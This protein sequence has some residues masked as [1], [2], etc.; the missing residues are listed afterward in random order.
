MTSVLRPFYFFLVISS[1]VSLSTIMCPGT[2]VNSSIH[3][4]CICPFG[5]RGGE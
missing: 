2:G 1:K 5:S 3:G 4:V